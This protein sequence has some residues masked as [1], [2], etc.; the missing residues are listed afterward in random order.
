[1]LAFYLLKLPDQTIRSDSKSLVPNPLTEIVLLELFL[2]LNAFPNK[3]A[4]III[5]IDAI[6]TDK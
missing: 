3:K 4:A 5:A 2:D 1:M 6:D